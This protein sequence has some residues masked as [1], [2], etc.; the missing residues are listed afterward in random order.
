[1][2]IDEPTGRGLD[3]VEPS[4]SPVRPRLSIPA[5]QR[6]GLPAGSP[7]DLASLGLRE[8]RGGDR[9]RVWPVQLDAGR[10]GRG[11]GGRQAAERNRR[12]HT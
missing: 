6:R 1:M 2:A 3:G 9:R 12:G 10:A 5:S 8:H 7:G 11:G 4:S